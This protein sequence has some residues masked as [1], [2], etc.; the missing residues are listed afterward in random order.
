[1]RVNSPS[2]FR[3]LRYSY[4]ITNLMEIHT[5][6]N[7]DLNPEPSQPEERE[8]QHL[9][10]KSY[11][12]AAA[13]DPE[14]S[15]GK[16]QRL[17]QHNSSEPQNL[18]RPQLNGTQDENHQPNGIHV[19]GDSHHEGDHTPEQYTGSGMD[20]SPRTPTRYGHKR[21][22]SMKKNGAKERENSEN[23]NNI[24][25]EKFQAADGEH[26]VSVKPAEGY[27]EALEQDGRE[28]KQVQ[29]QNESKGELVSG[30][31]A[32][33]GWEQSRCG[34]LSSSRFLHYSSV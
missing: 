22:S 24:V 15:A 5:M 3:G 34:G 17:A 1:M 18:E 4:R 33:A 12:D 16:E 7:F 13:P 6:S 14:P 27:E 25:Y 19:N 29:R 9:P 32:G 8:Q 2:S 23:E 21:M 10:P 28:R 26:L 31:Q 30:R 11:A 20:D